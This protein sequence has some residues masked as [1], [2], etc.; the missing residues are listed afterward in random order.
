MCGIAGIVRWD[1]GPPMLED[2][3]AMCD[4]M[5]HRGPDDEGFYHD[6]HAAIGMRRLSIID[7]G[8]GHQPISNEDGTIWVVLNG[9]IYNFKEL[10]ADLIARGHRFATT[11][12][13]ETIVHLYEDHGARAVEALRGM[14]AFAVWDSRRRELLIARDRLGIKP[15]YY[16]QAGGSMVFASELKAMLQVSGTTPRLN[17][18]ALGHLLT[19]GGTPADESIVHGIQ[20]LQPGCLA[21]LSG[22]QLRIE[23]YWSVEF[24]S[25]RQVSEGALVEELRALLAESVELHMRSD[26]PF[27]AFLSGGIDSSAIVATMS[28]LLQQPVKTFSIGSTDPRYDELAY[29]REVATAFGTEHHELILEPHTA[30][31]LEDLAWF[32]DEP[33]G[34]SSLVPTY[35][36]SKLAAGHVKVVL[37]GDGGDEIFAGYD[38]YVVEGRER[39]ERDSVPR[40]VRRVLAAVGAAMPE[41]MKGRNY[42]RHFA[43]DGARRYLNA[44]TVFGPT[45]QARLLEADAYA[46]VVQSDPLAAALAHLS[47]FDDWLSAAQRWDLQCYLPLDILPKVDRMTMAHS[48]EARPALLD[49]RLVEF[50]AAVPSRLRMQGSTTKYLFKRAMRGV[51]P[52]SVIDRTKRGFTLPFAS[53]FRGDWSAFVRDLLLSAAARERG[54]FRPSYVQRVVQLNDSGRDMSTQL[55]TLV[56][57]EL[58]CRAFLDGARRARPDRERRRAVAVGS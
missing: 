44:A 5:V 30:D 35:M 10:R 4:V 37:S 34:D 8:T 39:E 56:S 50:A 31:I 26:V 43:Y 6:R 22:G 25:D 17:L 18:G 24:S 28:R 11:S 45:E 16:A 15:L 1:G 38:K 40:Q 33:L 52:D 2:V 41:G 13:T 12:D 23:R 21:T 20:K 3:Q 42:L 53:W 19:F 27:G 9:E 7:L 48:L 58:W 36:V 54:L 14:F 55:W 47:P 29:A 57:F 32:Q 51:L 46:G 49:H